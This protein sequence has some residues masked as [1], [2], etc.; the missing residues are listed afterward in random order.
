M[1]LDVGQ[2]VLNILKAE[3]INAYP[4]LPASPARP[5]VQVQ[6][7]GGAFNRE[8]NGHLNRQDLQIDVWGNTRAETQQVA[9]QVR[10]LLINAR[11]AVSDDGVVLV[12]ARVSMPSFF[13]DPEFPVG[14]RPGP[15]FVMIASVT[16]HD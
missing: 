3:S 1:T 7:A 4:A 5:I 12:G 13:R 11:N 6:E 15:R 14:N 9:A 2:L 8:A 16:A 10:D